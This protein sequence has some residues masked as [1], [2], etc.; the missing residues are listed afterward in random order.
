[1]IDQWFNNL[2]GPNTVIVSLLGTKPD[3][4][5]EHSFY[6]FYKKQTFQ[7]W[8]LD[9][10]P[11]RPIQVIEH[12]TIDFTTISNEVLAAVESDVTRLLSKG[13]TVILVDSGGETRTGTVCKFMQFVED[14]RKH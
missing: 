4:V 2:P 3:G 10:Y 13:L 12:P 8:L 6:S 7:E 1:V 9:R 5:S 11:D 14:S